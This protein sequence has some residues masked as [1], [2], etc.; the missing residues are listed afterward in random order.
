MSVPKGVIF[1]LDQTLVDS[2]IAEA[3]RKSRNWKGVY[4][5]IPQ[6]KIYEGILETIESIKNQNIQIC[7]L[8][9]SPSVYCEKV[10][11]HFQLTYDQKV[12]YHDTKKHKPD[13]EPFEKALSLMR[14]EAKD[15]FAFGDKLEDAV[16]ANRASIPNAICTWG[17]IKQKYDFEIENDTYSVINFVSEIPNCMA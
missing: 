3:E 16:G 4:K 12:C 8:T 6:F 15:V 13:P 11:D 7:I 5:L 1:D 2:S 17:T 14:L 9:S 10:L